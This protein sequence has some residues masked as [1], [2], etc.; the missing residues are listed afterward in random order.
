MPADVAGLPGRRG[1]SGRHRPQHAATPALTR[2]SR[3]R[4]PNQLTVPAARGGIALGLGAVLAVSVTS[5]GSGTAGADRHLAQRAVLA[6]LAGPA[7]QA[8]QA[9]A[10]H[11]GLRSVQVTASAAREAASAAGVAARVR[12]R[13]MDAALDLVEQG[14][15][16]V[17]AAAAASRRREDSAGPSRDGERGDAPPVEQAAPEVRFSTPVTGSLTSRYGYRW[18]RLHRGIDYGAA[19]GAPVR[20]VGGGTVE[21]TGWSHGLGYQVRVRLDDG[22]LLVYGHLSQVGVASGQRVATGQRLGAVGNSGRS[23]GPHLHLEVHLGGVAVDPLP[24]LAARGVAP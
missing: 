20:A 7:Q 10:G 24:W 18:G 11:A 23:T 22:A 12:A 9:P 4:E 19:Y 16:G 14:G 8:V 6:E 13:S 2:G 17:R 15:E 3:H 21:M 1:R 5:A